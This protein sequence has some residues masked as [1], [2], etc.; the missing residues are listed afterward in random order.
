MRGSLSRVA[1]TLRVSLWIVPSLMTALA[2]AAALFT[3]SLDREHQ[4]GP[5]SS[6][7]LL[8]SGGPE[9]AR[10]MLS[11]IATSMITV[12][13]VAFSITI[14]A[15]SLASQQFGSRVLRNFMMD[16]GNQTV[17]GTFIATFVYCLLVLRAVRGSEERSFVPEISVSV[18]IALSMASLGV[19]IYFI[20]H[21]SAS[22]QADHVVHRIAG[23]L[24]KSIERF[25]QTVKD[26]PPGVDTPLP[27]GEN[28][29]PIRAPRSGY[30]RFIDER[31]LVLIAAERRLR[32]T[33][34]HRAGQ[35]VF[36][37][38]IVALVDGAAAPDLDGVS[39]AFDLTAIR[40]DATDMEYCI[41]QLVEVG[42]R[43]LSPAVNS[44]FTAILCINHLGAA[45]ASLINEPFP[46]LVVADETG[47]PRLQ[48]HPLTFAMI[49]DSAFGQITH[50]G[51]E[52]PAIARR[53]REVF[54]LLGDL[55]QTADRAATVRMHA[56]AVLDKAR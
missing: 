6:L 12:A 10:Q 54:A 50:F 39:D 31:L 36:A 19:L 24:Q 30:L 2:V 27:P 3:V 56:T 23:E 32:I 4:F 45:M 15:L 8:Y 51:A 22:I 17:L 11:A 37:G 26:G 34:Q 41:D 52:I 42:V 35:F 40:P 44:P 48:R 16:R 46:P 18:A 49:F 29:V 55:A 1:D 47:A 13:G 43:A 28:D 33:M 53:L 20:H 14:V 21:V 9:G 25:H 7:R 5:G 38:N